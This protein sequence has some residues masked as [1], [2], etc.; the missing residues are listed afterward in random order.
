MPVSRCWEAAGLPSA[1]PKNSAR[2]EA[3][4]G[5]PTPADRQI[6]ELAAAARTPEDH[7]ALEGYFVTLAEKS[8]KAADEHVAMAAAYRGTR[9]STAAAHCDRLV[10]LSREAARE[11]L[12]AAAEHKKLAQTN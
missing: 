1:A 12:A 7:R 3:G 8:K 10:K 5:A 9:N 4:E 11:A 6:Q 2:F